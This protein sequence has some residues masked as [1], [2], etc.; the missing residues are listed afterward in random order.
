MAMIAFLCPAFFQCLIFVVKVRILFRAL[1]SGKGALYE[2]RLEVVSSVPC[3]CGFLLVGAFIVCRREPCPGGK[4]G[5]VPPDGHIRPYL[6]EDIKGG[7]CSNADHGDKRADDGSIFL[8]VIRQ[9]FINQGDAFIEVIKMY[10]DDLQLVALDADELVA[11]DALQDIFPAGPDAVVHRPQDRLVTDLARVR[12]NKIGHDGGCGFPKW[13]GKHG[14]QTDLRNGQGI[15]VTVLFGS[16]H[17]GKLETVTAQF[18][19]ITDIGGR[20]KRRNHQIHPEQAGHVDGIPEVCFAPACLLH[21]FGMC[22]H[23]LKPL[24]FQYVIDRDPVFPG[25]LHADILHAIAF[26]PFGHP[27]DITVGRCKLADIKNGSKSVWVCPA[28]R[29]HEDFLMDVNARADLASDIRVRRSDDAGPVVK[30]KE[31][32]SIPIYN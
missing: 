5:D 18:P 7:I 24:V 17:I 21:I 22:Q 13:V 26:E 3:L 30:C 29:G 14:I 9:F 31:L 1:Y 19:E 20:D 27:S 12:L 2:E 11:M 15:L 6:T 8:T 16:P 32:D 25:G 4:G 23:R 10:L 28:D